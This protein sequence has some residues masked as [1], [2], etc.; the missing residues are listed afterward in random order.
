LCF[1]LQ[2][3]STQGKTK[4]PITKQTCAESTYI[5]RGKDKGRSAWHYIL[6]PYD[7]I[8]YMNGHRIGDT[9]DITKFGR[10]IEYR[11]EQGTL[12]PLSGWGQDPPEETQK[13]I[14]AEYGMPSLFPF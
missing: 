5:I 11:D 12:H 6:V 1:I 9:L 13:W 8:A 7:Q 10:V 4:Q 14:E 3:S 2:T